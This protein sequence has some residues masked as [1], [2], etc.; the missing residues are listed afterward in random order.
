MADDQ[1]PEII[2]D[3]DWKARV[4]RE[5]EEAAKAPEEAPSGESKDK[6]APSPFEGMVSYLATHAMGAMGMF[7]ARDATEVQVNLEAA[8][9]VIDGLMALREKTKGNLSAEEEGNLT[10]MI[11]D[12][13]RAYV[14]CSQAV[15]ETAMRSAAPA[16]EVAQP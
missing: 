6:A 4:E 9:F 14:T 15:Q 5:K 1:G 7:A 13:Q 11:G 16:P 10:A 12:L 2:I 8:K 3:E